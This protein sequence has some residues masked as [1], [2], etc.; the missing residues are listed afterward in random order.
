M[1]RSASWARE[2]KIR[3]PPDEKGD[4]AEA[5]PPMTIQVKR[6]IGAIPVL[7]ATEGIKGNRAGQTT[8]KVLLKKERNARACR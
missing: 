1:S 7:C 4:M 6:R 2:P 8:P 5:C 3:L